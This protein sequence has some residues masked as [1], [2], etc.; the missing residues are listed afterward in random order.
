MWMWSAP[1]SQGIWERVALRPRPVVTIF[2][3]TRTFVSRRGFRFFWVR[4]AGS[5]HLYTLVRQL[6]RIIIRSY[7]LQRAPVSWRMP[8]SVYQSSLVCDYMYIYLG[9]NKSCGDIS[10][11]SLVRCTG[12]TTM[13]P[14]SQVLCRVNHH[15]VGQSQTAGGTRTLQQASLISSFQTASKTIVQY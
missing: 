5:T 15:T 6:C 12:S 11:S 13:L 14:G 10:L 8:R 1:P 3:D 7:V 2:L 4:L 9:I